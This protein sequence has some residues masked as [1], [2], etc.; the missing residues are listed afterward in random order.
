MTKTFAQQRLDNGNSYYF[1]NDLVN[2]QSVRFNGNAIGVYDTIYENAIV[3]GIAVNG[4]PLTGKSY[5]LDIT[6]TGIKSEYDTI[7][8]SEIFIE[9]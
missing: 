3:K 6:N 9:S 8:V 2:N 7:V 5:I 1:E 4:L